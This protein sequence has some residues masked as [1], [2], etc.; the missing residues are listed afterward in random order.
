MKELDKYPIEFV[1]NLYRQ[2]VA[3]E[4]KGDE[5]TIMMLEN[6]YPTLFSNEFEDFISN[7]K[8]SIEYIRHKYDEDFRAMLEEEKIV[9]H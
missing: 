7:M 5:T 3:A 8:M 9:H 6:K 4:K 1:M 2:K